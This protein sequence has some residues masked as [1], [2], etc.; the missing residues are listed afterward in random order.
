MWGT[1][2]LYG[3]VCAPIRFI[4]THV[5]NTWEPRQWS[6]VRS[7]HPHA[8]GEHSLGSRTST[9]CRGSS[10]RMW[11]TRLLLVLCGGG[12]R[13]IPMHVGNTGPC[14][15]P[16]RINPVHP[17]ACG[18]HAPLRYMSC[19]RPGSSPRMWG[20][21]RPE[22]SCGRQGRFIPTHVGN[23][24]PNP[25]PYGGHAVHPHACG[26]HVTEAFLSPAASGSSPRMWGTRVVSD[27][28]GSHGR[29]IPTHVGNTSITF[30]TASMKSVHPHACGEHY[31]RAGRPGDSAGSSP[32][33]WGTP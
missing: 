9:V 28:D 33:M 14:V 30:F 20:T 24:R 4:P 17:H 21:R 12:S 7:V 6:C 15:T 3:R 1:R 31:Q 2:A 10:P 32:R 13:F 16:T 8:C 18:E 29:F 19:I 5:G 23:T 26:E 11:G 25:A 27:Q 22:G